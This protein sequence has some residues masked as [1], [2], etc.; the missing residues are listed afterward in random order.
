MQYNVRVHVHGLLGFKCPTQ[1]REEENLWWQQFRAN[2]IILYY[3]WCQTTSNV[4][5]V[6]TCAVPSYPSLLMSPRFTISDPN[7]AISALPVI[8]MGVSD[9]LP[10]KRGGEEREGKREREGEG[11]RGREG[12]R[13][14]R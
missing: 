11:E 6:D 8:I 5:H 14:R 7:R 12:G 9:R 4:I 10:C 1:C 2:L 3:N 13:D